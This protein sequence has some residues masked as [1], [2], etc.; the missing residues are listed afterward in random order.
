MASSRLTGVAGTSGVVKSG[1]D[2]EG[3]ECQNE[4][5]GMSENNGLSE[6]EQLMKDKIFSR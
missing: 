4:H 1:S 3:H 6:I 5:A 2:F